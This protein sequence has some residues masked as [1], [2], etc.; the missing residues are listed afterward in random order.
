MKMDIFSSNSSI[1]KLVEFTLANFGTEQ[2]SDHIKVFLSSLMPNLL[3]NQIFELQSVDPRI[4]LIGHHL[5]PSTS[6][7]LPKSEPH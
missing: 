7:N 5:F 6:N 3:N 2:S 1:A 4:A